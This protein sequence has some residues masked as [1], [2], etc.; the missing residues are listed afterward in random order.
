[1]NASDRDDLAVALGE[2]AR[3]LRDAGD[4]VACDLAIYFDRAAVRL[5]DAAN[6]AWRAE[7]F[8]T[9]PPNFLRGRRPETNG[10]PTADTRE[11]E[12]AAC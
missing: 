11:P 4:S 8:E 10:D 9:S 12:V 6:D 3:Q 1:M 5:F 2:I 7:H